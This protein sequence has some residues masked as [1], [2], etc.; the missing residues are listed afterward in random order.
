M[1]Y[2]NECGSKIRGI[3]LSVLIILVCV[4]C[5]RRL[6]IEVLLLAFCA[7]DAIVFQKLVGKSHVFKLL[8]G[9]SVK[10]EPIRG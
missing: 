6:I 3:S 5:G 4:V 9:L 2:A 10:F 7:M 8:A 1:S